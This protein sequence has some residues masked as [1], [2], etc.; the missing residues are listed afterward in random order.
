M[1]AAKTNVRMLVLYLHFLHSNKQ[2]RK[3]EDAD[4]HKSERDCREN[5][6]DWHEYIITWVIVEHNKNLL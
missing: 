4:K 5:I 1:A 3:F 6:I 2:W